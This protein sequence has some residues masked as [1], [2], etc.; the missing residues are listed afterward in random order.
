MVSTI[1]VTNLT[2]ISHPSL[3]PA[4]RPGSLVCSDVVI[5]RKA[6]HNIS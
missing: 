6:Y 3:E 5:G 1:A 2:A 4:D